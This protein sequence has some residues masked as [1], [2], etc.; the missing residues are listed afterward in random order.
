M[1]CIL[2][3]SST[4]L[5]ANDGVNFV[6]FRHYGNR[7]LPTKVSRKRYD[8]F[9][10]KLVN[11]S[12]SLEEFV[13]SYNSVTGHLLHADFYQIIKH[14]EAIM[15]GQFPIHIFDSADGVFDSWGFPKGYVEYPTFS[16][17]AVKR[18]K[19]DNRYVIYSKD[20]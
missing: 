13:R 17:F 10:E 7:I 6:G 19:E 1:K 20:Q 16:R 4:I 2:N 14:T 5:Y 3:D 18:S 9:I 11:G 12:I 15:R 8:E